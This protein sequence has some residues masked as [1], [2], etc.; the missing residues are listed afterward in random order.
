MQ[1]RILPGA[2]FHSPPGENEFRRRR[3]WTRPWSVARGAVLA[4]PT[5][6]LKGMETVI[7]PRSAVAGIKP[8]PAEAN[9]PERGESSGGRLCYFPASEEGS[10]RKV[11]LG[12]R[13][14]EVDAARRV[15]AEGL[16]GEAVRP[17]ASRETRR[18]MFQSSG[19]GPQ[20]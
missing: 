8:G 14:K 11:V 10:H 13:P 15:T 7:Q 9:N 4:S 5:H 17:S 18:S 6:M 2:P 19:G 12:A 3:G 20:S 1:V 16:D